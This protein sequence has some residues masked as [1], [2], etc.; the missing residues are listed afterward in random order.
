MAQ[1]Q[2]KRGGGG[3]EDDDVTP[4]RP[5]ARSVARSSPKTPTICWTRSMTSSKRTLRTLC[6]R[7]SK[8]RTVTW[9][10]DRLPGPSFNSL[11]DLSSFS[12]FLRRQAPDLL[13]NV[14]DGV[15]S[16]ADLPHGTTIVALKYPGGVLIA[17][18]GARPRAT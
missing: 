8:G 17:G 7:T 15:G 4:A 12:D 6:A 5:P 13:P 10:N 18:T 1:E 3:G 14:R 2:T 9:P 16:G 11:S